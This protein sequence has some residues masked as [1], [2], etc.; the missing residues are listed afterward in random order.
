MQQ[1]G[2]FFTRE[3]LKQQRLVCNVFDTFAT[4][5]GLAY[6]STDKD[7]WAQSGSTH[8]CVLTT[9]KCCFF[10]PTGPEIVWTNCWPCFFSFCYVFFTTLLHCDHDLPSYSHHHHSFLKCIVCRNHNIYS[11]LCVVVGLW[12]TGLVI[13]IIVSF[14]K[15]V[16]LRGHNTYYTLCKNCN[17]KFNS[18]EENWTL[19]ATD[20]HSACKSTTTKQVS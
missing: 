10:K 17:A 14:L 8:S 11:M 20:S 6:D 19:I 4:Y 12:T 13:I 15:L 18:W 9:F 7:C 16:A 5:S 3:W 1:F 2:S